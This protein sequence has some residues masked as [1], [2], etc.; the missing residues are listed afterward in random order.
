MHT[1]HVALAERDD[2]EFG[3]TGFRDCFLEGD[4]G[5]RGS[6]F[7]LR[8]MAFED[9]AVVAVFE[10]SGRRA[11]DVEEKVYPNRKIAAIKK[12]GL[13]LGDEFTNAGK[14]AV[15]AGGPDDNIFT[16]TNAGRKTIKHC[17]GCGEVDD[18]VDLGEAGS[19]RRATGIVR[20]PKNPNIV[21]A[22]PSNFGHE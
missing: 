10:S 13:I 17:G 21:L 19:E 14:L 5:A 3:A 12:A 16:G 11:R 9:L 2:L 22:M 20:C 4:C 7:L 15:P 6:V 18:R 8:V 1:N